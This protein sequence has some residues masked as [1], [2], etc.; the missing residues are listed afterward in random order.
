MGVSPGLGMV[1]FGTTFLC[2]SGGLP[3]GLAS[4]LLLD[5]LSL[6][7]SFSS[8]GI[9]SLNLTATTRT[10]LTSTP[11]II[12]RHEWGSCLKCLRL[13]RVWVWV[14]RCQVGSIWHLAKSA[15]CI[16]LHIKEAQ[17]QKVV[18]LLFNYLSVWE[19]FT[20]NLPFTLLISM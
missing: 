3:S 8:L 4:A 17:T 1:L 5:K 13:W 19:T 20:N 7:I 9:S 11:N 6:L 16:C 15:K 18:V 14:V 10:L 12:S 2:S